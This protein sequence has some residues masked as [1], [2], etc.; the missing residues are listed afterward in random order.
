MIQA[1]SPD[2]TDH[3]LRVR[4]LPRTSWSCSYF[5]DTKHLRLA[6]ELAAVDRIP[7]ADEVPRRLFGVTSLRKLSCRPSRGRVRRDVDLQNPPAV[8]PQDHQH[9]QDP[10]GGRRHREEI[11]RD[12]ALR[13]IP[14]KGL[15]GLCGRATTSVHVLRDCRFGHLD[16][17]LQ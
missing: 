14:E 15:P 17:Q 16:L 2:R 4:I 11:Q 10:E 5:V 7:I 12:D 8:V 1:L 9:E 3:A 13:V 6:T